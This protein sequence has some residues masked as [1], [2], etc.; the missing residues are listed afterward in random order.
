MKNFTFY[1]LLLLLSNL[2]IGCVQDSVQII[3]EDNSITFYQ[4]N[5]KSKQINFDKTGIILNIQTFNNQKLLTEWVPD[6][7]NLEQFYEYYGNGQ[8]KVKGYLKNQK[9]HSLWSYFDREGHLLIERY[10]SYGEPNNIWIWYDHHDHHKIEK[11]HVYNDKRDDGY[12][13]RY[14]QSS[15]IKEQ[16]SYVNNKLN[17]SYNLFYDNNNNAIHLKGNYLAG[18]K[19][20][21]WEIFDELG[22]FQNFFK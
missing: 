11:F 17:G 19:I 4:S 5:L 9:K 22:V 10:F 7:S 21:N 15:N 6:N 13:T 12:F 20:N 3:K 14:Y 18:S 1:I 16:K 2:F 8:I